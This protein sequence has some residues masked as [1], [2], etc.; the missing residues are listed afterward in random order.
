MKLHRLSVHNF[1]SIINADVEIHDYTMIVGANN[2]G[3]SNLL[4]ALRAFYEDI[5]WSVEDVPRVGKSSDESWVQ[6]TFKLTDEEWSTLADKYK[7]DENGNLLT[8]R[9]YFASSAAARFNAK[10]SNIFGVVKGEIEDEYF[11]GAKNIGTAKLGG[12]IYIP[13]QTSASE[14]MKTTG[15]SPLREMLNFMLK[16]VLKDSPA[17]AEVEVAFQKL[18]AEA[19]GESGFIEKITKPINTAMETWEVRFD[20]SINPVT[21]DDITKNLIKHAFVDCVL[22]GAGFALDRFGHGFQ[23]SFLYELIKLAPDFVEAK[24]IIKKEFDPEFTLILFEEPEAFLHPAQQENMAYHLREMGTIDG[25]QVIITSHSPIF[26]GKVSDDLCQ[27]VRA[28]RHNGITT[29]G[30]I[31]RSR[32]KD[33]FAEGL[34]LRECLEE[35]VNDT[36]VNEVKK[37]AA[38]NLLLNS[39]SE[40][41]MAIQKEQFQYQLWIDSERSSMFFAD[42]VLIVEGATEKALFSWLI[43]RKWRDL[44]KYHVSVIDAMGKFNFHRYVALLEKFEISYGLMLDDDEDKNHHVAINEML[45]NRPG[46]HRLSEVV[47]IPKNMESFLGKELPDSNF[48]KPIRIIQELESEGI[49]TDKIL[50][51]RKKFCRALGIEGPAI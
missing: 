7:V 41:D 21:Q 32:A 1:R 12:V 22:G 47:F 37:R 17:Y 42:R 25:Q 31:E 48:N 15:P 46:N 38:R 34:S 43:A 50:L 33:V 16:R 44:S 18:N 8:V 27:I 20:I 29:L 2:A 40:I 39:E 35:F 3:K 26:V 45:K 10:Q 13:A 23:R 51:L 28:H 24:K 19:C 49:D 30:Q 14:Q 4:A 9:R 6:L 11:Y 36:A 5:K